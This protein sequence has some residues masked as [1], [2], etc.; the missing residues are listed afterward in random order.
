M[1]RDGEGV[2]KNGP[3]AVGWFKKAA[4]ENY[5]DAALNLG[6]MYRDGDGVPA[7]RV[8]SLEWFSRAKAMNGDDN[9][10]DGNEDMPL[11]RKSIPI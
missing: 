3:E 1:Y 7:D 4:A 2:A 6:V 10:P 8:K 11:Q 5:A 9:E